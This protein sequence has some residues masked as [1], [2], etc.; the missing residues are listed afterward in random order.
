MLICKLWEIKEHM[1]PQE[2]AKYGAIIHH[3]N[4][5]VIL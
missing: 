1:T 3:F 5:N 4:P 2:I